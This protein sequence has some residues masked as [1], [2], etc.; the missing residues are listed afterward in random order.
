MAPRVTTGAGWI[1]T[2][3]LDMLPVSFTYITR[4]PA[5]LTMVYWALLPGP[6]TDRKTGMIRGWPM[7]EAKS[8]FTP[9]LIP[10]SPL[11]LSS[12]FSSKASC[13]P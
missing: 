5:N 8:S 6:T 1:M 9:A 3:L 7:I 2:F 12:P 4:T 10:V 13:P 11:S